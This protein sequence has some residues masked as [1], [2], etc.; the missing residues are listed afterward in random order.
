VD[1]DPRPAMIR[2]QKMQPINVFS[3]PVKNKGS[4]FGKT[5][6]NVLIEN[7]SFSAAYLV[8]FLAAL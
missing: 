8:F 4:G 1:Y 2:L 3:D 7:P 5:K 6:S